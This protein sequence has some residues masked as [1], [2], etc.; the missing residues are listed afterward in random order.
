[1]SSDHVMELRRRYVDALATVEHASRRTES[2]LEE[3]RR[4]W[5]VARELVESGRALLEF[6]QILDPHPLRAGLADALTELEST[7][8]DAQRLLFLLL[9]A[10][11]R[12]L[13]EIGRTY[14]ISRQLVSR[15]VNEADPSLDGDPEPP[16]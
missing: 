10:E 3:A 13:A 12:T 4:G 8:H 6:E 14:G 9:Q 11:G 7:R 16:A 15:L 2:A 1:M 5:D